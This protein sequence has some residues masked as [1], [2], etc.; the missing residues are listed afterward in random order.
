[1]VKYFVENCRVNV[2]PKDVCLACSGGHLE[3]VKYL[4]K[5][6]GVQ[7]EYMRG[8]SIFGHLE[9]VKYLVEECGVNAQI[10]I[11]W[12]SEFGRID[13]LKYLVEECDTITDSFSLQL[14]IRNK[15]SKVI[16]YLA[17][18]WGV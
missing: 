14:A 1:M 7:N 6:C 12:A 2:K 15:H 16:K 11:K 5:E 9:V 17:E 10:G 8:A 4:I 3:V 18:K 13:V